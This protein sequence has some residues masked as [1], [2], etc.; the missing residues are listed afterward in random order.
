MSA[1]TYSRFLALACAFF[2]KF[3]YAECTLLD[4]T[5]YEGKPAAIE[6]DFP[7]VPLLYASSFW[8]KDENREGLPD[9]ERFER[10]LNKVESPTGLAILDIEAWPVRGYQ[11]RPWVV[12]ESINKYI[13]TLDWAEAD[14]PDLVWSM[15][16]RLPTSNYLA[17]ISD[18]GAEL[19]KRWQSENDR[20]AL[21]AQSVSIAFPSMYTYEESPQ[22]WLRSFRAK[23]EELKRIYEGPVYAFIWPQYFDH[24]PTRAD[25]RL[26]F[27]P[28]EFWRYQL[29][30]VCRELD[31]AVIW[32]GWDFENGRRAKWD[33]N[34][35]W[36]LETHAFI[37]DMKNNKT[38]ADKG[39]Q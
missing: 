35:G 15:F 25:L 36:W 16:G 7:S 32:G 28:R 39:A 37:E 23:V 5:K 21:L 14:R 20:M 22:N 3:S 8:S 17:S 2:F 29:E 12:Q 6:T 34:A 10:V 26:Q 38:T 19:Y 24:E 27:I 30:T 11:F 4:G 1:S 18:P 13:T 9:R 33:E 31:G